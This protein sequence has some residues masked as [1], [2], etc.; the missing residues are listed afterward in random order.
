MLRRL[1]DKEAA[2]LDCNEQ[3]RPVLMETPGRALCANGAAW[4][5]AQ[6]EV[7]VALSLGSRVPWPGRWCAHTQRRGWAQ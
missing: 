1:E 3:V 7:T 4:T 6:R 2:Q 5:G